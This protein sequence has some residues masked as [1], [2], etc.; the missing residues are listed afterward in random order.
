[1]NALGMYPENP[2]ITPLLINTACESTQLDVECEL[3]HYNT[4][5]LLYT[6]LLSDKMSDFFY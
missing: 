4:P 1:M 2:A 6:K 5:D 3:C